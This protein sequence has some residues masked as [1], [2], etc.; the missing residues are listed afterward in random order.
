MSSFA[1]LNKGVT[2]NGQDFSDA[3]EYRDVDFIF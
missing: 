2:D 1:F 3:Q